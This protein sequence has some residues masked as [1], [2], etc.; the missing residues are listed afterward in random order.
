MKVSRTETLKGVQFS[1]YHGQMLLEQKMATFSMQ[2]FVTVI[3]LLIISVLM[4][5]FGSMSML[6][7]DPRPVQIF[8]ALLCSAMFLVPMIVTIRERLKKPTIEVP[9]RPENVPKESLFAGCRVRWAS[10]VSVKSPGWIWQEKGLL[11]FR[12]EWF[13]WQLKPE[14]FGGWRLRKSIV[15][16]S[17]K[18]PRSLLQCTL[19]VYPADQ[20]AFVALLAQ[21]QDAVPSGGESIFPPLEVPENK[22]SMGGLWMPVTAVAAMFALVIGVIIKALPIDS[23]R[24]RPEMPYLSGLCVFALIMMLPLMLVAGSSSF[25]SHAKQLAKL[26]KGG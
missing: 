24:E 9:E 15:Q 12:G 6:R 10:G 19:T 21:W 8:G 2:F 11:I 25:K 23:Y 14:D 13:D 22:F 1:R 26:R 16:R 4:L 5:Y 7:G 17:L 18:L 3:L 20:A